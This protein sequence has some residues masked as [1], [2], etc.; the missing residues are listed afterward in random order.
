M[1]LW[2]ES[3]VCTVDMHCTVVARYLSCECMYVSTGGVCEQ[4]VGGEAPKNAPLHA[5][6]RLRGLARCPSSSSLGGSE[7]GAL[8]CDSQIVVAMLLCSVLLI[9]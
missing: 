4:C 2:I 6:S 5:K 3:T 8:C 1:N 7:S 9:N